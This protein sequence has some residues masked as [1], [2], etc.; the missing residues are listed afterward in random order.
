[1]LVSKLTV[2]ETKKQNKHGVVFNF[3]PTVVSGTSRHHHVGK[4]THILKSHMQTYFEKLSEKATD[5]EINTMMQHP[6]NITYNTRF[7]SVWQQKKQKKPT[8]LSFNIFMMRLT[9]HTVLS[10][11][12]TSCSGLRHID[13]GSFLDQQCFMS[14]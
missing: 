2:N 14:A 11:C 5:D 12:R 1:M 13:S 6:P 3:Y 10:L 9:V 4:H 8:K 7:V